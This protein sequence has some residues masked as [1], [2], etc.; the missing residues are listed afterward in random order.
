MS[1][2]DSRKLAC[3]QEAAALRAKKTARLIGAL[4]ICQDLRHIRA[5]DED[6]LRAIQARA[7]QLLQ[8]R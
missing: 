1:G 2:W 5:H 7:E 8:Q 4:A 6:A 3:E